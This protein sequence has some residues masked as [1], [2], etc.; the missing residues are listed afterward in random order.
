MPLELTGRIVSWLPVC[1]FP[2][3]AQG[4]KEWDRDM[5]WFLCLLLLVASVCTL[6]KASSPRPGSRAA[7]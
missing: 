7:G 6:K 4:A 1:R 2:L 5:Y 3:H